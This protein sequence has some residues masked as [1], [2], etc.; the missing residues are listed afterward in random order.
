MF[1][2][3]TF[4]LIKSTKNR[5][6]A[7]FLIVSIGVGFMVGLLDSSPVLQASVDDYIDETNFFD[8]QVYSSYGFCQ[9]DIDALSEVEGVSVVYG[10]K[11]QDFYATSSDTGDKIV[12]RFQEIFSDINELELVSGRWP[13][14][15][16]E[17][18]CLDSASFG[19]VYAIGDTITIVSE[20]WDD[21]L[22][23][24]E[25]TIVGT[26][27]T[28]LY[29]AATKETSNLDNK[30]ISA[31]VF[32]DSDSFIYEYYTTVY[33]LFEDSAS[34]VSF[35]D[36]YQEYIDEMTVNTQI[37]VDSQEGYLKEKLLTEY[38]EEIAEAEETLASESAD[39][40]AQLDE[41]KEQLDAAYI[42]LLVAEAQ[43]T[44][45]QATLEA[46]QTQYNTYS[47]QIEAN[48]ELLND[49][50]AQIEET[51]GMSFDEVYS[52]VSASYSTYTTIQNIDT[53]SANDEISSQ[54]SS[55]QS[56]IEELEA[57][58]ET[59]QQEIDDLNQQIE[60]LDTTSETYEDDLAA[61]QQE[62]DD[63]QSEIT[64]NEASISTLE[65][66]ISVLESTQSSITE[67]EK[68]NLLDAIDEQFADMGFSGIED[69]YTQLTALNEGL[70]E[71]EDGKEQLETLY[72]TILSYQNQI[73]SAQKSVDDG[74]D[75]YYAGLE[76]YNE[77][78]IVFEEEI[79]NAQYEI[80]KAKQ[81]LE[82]LPDAEWY[83]LDRDS[84]YSSYM[85]KNTL[86]QMTS[87]GIVIPVMFFLVAA[88]V[89]MTTMTRLIDEQRSQIG[90][91]L[92]LGYSKGQIISKYVTYSFLASI[93]GS[94]F[95]LIVGPL[96]IPIVIYEAWKL[97]YDLPDMR[98]YCPVYLMALGVLC[99]TL[100]MML[101]SALVARGQLKEK[102]SQLMRP[103][104]PKV[105]K[106]VFLEKI[107]FI[108]KRLS[109]TNKITAR[110]IIRYKSRFFMTV[111]GVAGCTALLVI[112]FGV[113]DSI[114]EIVEIQYTEIFTYDYTVNLEDDYTVDDLLDELNSDYDNDAVVPFVTY[115]SAVYL[116]DSD[117]LTINVVVMDA[118]DIKDVINLRERNSGDEL[119]IKTGCVISEKFA[120]DNDISVGD[121]ITIES[122]NGIKAEVEVTGICE[123]YAYHYLFISES[124][125]SRI[126]D[127]NIHYTN[128]A[129]D[130]T[131][132]EG[133]ISAMEERDDVISVTDFQTEEET[134]TKMFES[135]NLIIAVIILCAGA[136][137][138]VVVMN[139]TQVNISER[140]REIAT[141]K[142]LGFTHRE[143]YKYIFTE[144]LILTVIGALVGLPLGNVAES[145]VMNVISME[146]VM[147]G[148]VVKPMSY[149]Y[150]F[151]ITMGFTV[152][153]LFF[154]RKTLRNV[155][156]VESLKS[157]E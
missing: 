47:K 2:K 65:S 83:I 33:M 98:I 127:E 24:Q 148:Q 111:I 96:T 113:K 130:T 154:T 88:L 32:I 85:F 71:I 95:G 125:Y 79:E 142:V 72:Q 37:V 91:Y 44:T 128:I 80:E 131:D 119:D 108:W 34:Y 49:Y 19:A 30:S 59:L 87:I 26:V 75:E 76:D 70:S 136:L 146:M 138:F 92:A 140:I 73:S 55:L 38:E 29:M 69:A 56:Q 90:L 21:Y 53:S 109:F 122:N 121:T 23:V 20:D 64:A 107:P 143:I 58:N 101:V 126:F 150:A 14:N 66:T 120:S 7:L 114:S 35:S 129:V 52:L 149:V 89:C 8:I 17:A 94:V 40:Q 50:V 27:K 145:F 151:V 13:E 60:E 147:F 156:M 139:L 68:Q 84:H 106:K 46:Y 78:V 39:G 18:V 133:L 15:E 153:V 137:A 103:K 105:T 123:M 67:D 5:F 118:R 42:Q 99:F 62:V 86:S 116:D 28:P 115:S 77:A 54:I 11:Y 16:N 63:K 100:L 9:E 102:P 45:Y 117:D 6:I 104:S 141:L 43:I 10:S 1:H 22:T 132:G 81:D 110:N 41:A 74:Y 48:E 97:M 31:V 134:F 112:G 25:Y 3:D 61:L 152:I 135:L 82:E 36:A 144:V 157:V 124:T 4:R 155:Q 51:S 12:T 93:G 57:E